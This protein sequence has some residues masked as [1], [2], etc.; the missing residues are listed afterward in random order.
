MISL[1]GSR[2]YKED[3]LKLKLL[4]MRVLQK[5]RTDEGSLKPRIED[6]HVQ[7]GHCVINRLFTLSRQM[8]F[9]WTKHQIYDVVHNCAMCNANVKLPHDKGHVTVAAQVS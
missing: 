1:V 7:Y 5:T 2:L 4:V 6:V 9:L 8:R 3:L